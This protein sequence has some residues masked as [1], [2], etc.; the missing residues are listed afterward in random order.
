MIDQS[1]GCM[2]RDR[3]TRR[4]PNAV[5]HA[6]SASPYHLSY[7]EDVRQI[8]DRDREVDREIRLTLCS[9]RTRTDA[10]GKVGQTTPSFLRQCAPHVEERPGVRSLIRR[11]EHCVE[12][13]SLSL[14]DRAP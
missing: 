14:R 11:T 2:G 8:Q 1:C 9:P 6:S 4:N 7:L 5:T 13:R 3:V 10:D 12:A